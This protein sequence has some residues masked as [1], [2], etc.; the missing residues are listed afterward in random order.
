MNIFICV[1]VYWIEYD[2]ED[3]L[4]FRLSHVATLFRIDQKMIS[5]PHLAKIEVV[6]LV[7]ERGI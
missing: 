7:W 6:R 2:D 3:C 5:V 1:F 4:H